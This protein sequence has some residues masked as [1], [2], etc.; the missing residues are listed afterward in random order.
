M[1]LST[2]LFLRGTRLDY[3]YHVDS[4]LHSCW[5]SADGKSVRKVNA[6]GLYN[7]L[8]DYRESPQVVALLE[9]ALN[10]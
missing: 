7:F 10:G 8:R 4:R 6:G 9:W 5:S 1:R 3:E 2:Q